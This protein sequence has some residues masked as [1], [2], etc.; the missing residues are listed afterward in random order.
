MTLI[1]SV[2]N[3][4]FFYT[5]RPL[6]FRTISAGPAVS[7]VCHKVCTNDTLGENLQEIVT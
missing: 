6:Y 4:G 3:E 7:A 2:A 1:V 5:F